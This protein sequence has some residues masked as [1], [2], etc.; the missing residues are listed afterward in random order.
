MQRYDNF[1]P[2]HLCNKRQKQRIPLYQVLE[3]NNAVITPTHEL[4]KFILDRA[5]E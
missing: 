5:I 4:N 3:M 2:E 1:F